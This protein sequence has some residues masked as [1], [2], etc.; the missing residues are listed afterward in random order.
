M[1]SAS[2][3]LLCLPPEILVMITLH[4]EYAYEMNCLAQ[5]CQQLYSIANNCLFS[6][7][8]KEC[9]PR[10][11]DR[12]VKNDNARAL[13][14]LL[15][16]G[17]NFDQYFRTTGHST[18]ILLTV[19]T[20]LSRI[21]ELLVVYSEFSLKSDQC[22]Y[23]SSL[24]GP[25]H[26]AY[27]DDLEKTLYRAAIKGSLGVLKVLASSAAVKKW[28]ISLALAYAVN[29]GQLASARYLIEEAGVDVNQKIT[30]HGFF[31]SFLAL[32]ANRG[33]LE[34]VKLLVKAG[35]DLNCPSFQRIVQ[36]P[37]YIAAARNHGAVVQYLIEM[38]MRFSNVNF[39]DIMNLA[40]FSDLPDYTISNVVKGVDLYAV[41]AD[42][43]YHNCG[44][45]ARS[46]IYNVIAACDDPSLYQRILD[47]RRSS[48]DW[49]HVAGSFGIAVFH[50]HLT[51]ARYIVDE[52]VKSDRIVWGNEWSNLVSYTIYYDSAPAFDMLLDRGPPADLP[53][54]GKRWLKDVLAKA[55]DYPEHM[56]VLLQ[57][58]YLDKTIDGRVLQRMLAGAFEAGNLAFVRRLLKHGG[59]GLLDALDGP[60]VEYHEQTV[61][62]I[63]AYYSSLTTFQEFLSTQDL[64]LDPDHPT[65]CAALVS[66]AMGA[67]I[68]IINY[69]LGQGFDINA[70]YETSASKDNVAETLIIQVATAWGSPDGHT[71]KSIREDV[72]AAIKLLLDHGAQID[73]RNSQGLAPLSIALE[74]GNSELAHMLFS[75][76]ADPLIALESRADLSG[77]EQLIRIFK[78]NEHD[79]SYL[80]MLQAS[81]EVMAARG[82]QSDDFLRLTPSIEGTLSRPR[83]ISQVQDA[84]SVKGPIVLPYYEDQ[85]YVRWSHFFLIRE[86]RKRYWRAV[87][88]VP[89]E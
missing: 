9:S 38:G 46:C 40:E 80:D 12:I 43:T 28:Q 77:L 16:N 85:V 24:G 37:L 17:L 19:D 60:D 70:L 71:D 15:M 86:L 53:E 76:G 6:Y 22:K 31:E 25:G 14:K 66:A 33:N 20:D 74:T 50:G 39:F 56:E 61:L 41:M 88:P 65:H 68:D 27:E 26:R 87:Y 30:L 44:G 55:R 4:L 67:N 32:S 57:R 84:P 73:T 59:I 36:S 2:T 62:H 29:R 42:P 54:A 47:M 7:Y 83:V 69:F 79:V 23:G 8:A 81:L 58:G 89:S 21:A 49:Q 18:P 78:R 13:Y 10:G 75:R 82:Y 63:A 3:H 64:T 51:V 52:M 72:A 35:A 45:Y 48:H 11:L 34:M 5:T 1:Q